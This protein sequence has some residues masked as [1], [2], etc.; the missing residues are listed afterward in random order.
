LYLLACRLYVP[1]FP[2]KLCL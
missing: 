1:F 2:F